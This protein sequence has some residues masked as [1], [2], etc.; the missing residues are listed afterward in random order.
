MFRQYLGKAK[1]KRNATVIQEQVPF[2]WNFPEI[3]FE[4]YNLD[5]GY[6]DCVAIGYGVLGD[7]ATYGFG[8]LYVEND[9]LIWVEGASG[10][11]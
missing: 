11:G 1:I 8:S 10:K 3:I 7:Y 4:V 2:R 5:A 6:K 9:D